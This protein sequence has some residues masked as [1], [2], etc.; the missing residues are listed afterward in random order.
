MSGLMYG[1]GAAHSLNAYLLYSKCIE[2][3]DLLY[4]YWFTWL[5]NIFF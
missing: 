5:Y 2:Y 4:K 3:T 1:L